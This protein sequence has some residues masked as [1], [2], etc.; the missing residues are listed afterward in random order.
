MIDFSLLALDGGWGWQMLAGLAV[1]LELAVLSYLFG[2]ALGLLLALGILSGGRVASGLIES[3]CLVFRSVPELLII[4]LFYYGSALA[5]QAIL[6]PFGI[7]WR[8]EIGPFTAGVIAISLIQA[9]YTS[10]IFRGAI[11][12]VPRGPQEA[13]TALGLTPYQTFRIV[14]LPIAFR[15]A[16]PG[17][18]NMWLV[19]L[20]NTPLVSAIGLHDLIRAAGTAGQNTKQ[21][22][23]FYVTVLA[24][25]L[26][27]SAL[28]MAAQRAAERRVFRYV[29]EGR[30]G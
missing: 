10:E 26:V 27:V 8:I 16:F 22:F 25:Y 7:G 28:S 12:A 19:V 17:L 6:A 15:Y 30:G 24:V 2:T 14:V 23:T 21:Y 9:A 3:G 13:A 29:T 5:L 1:T 11:L 4:F 18:A 20:K